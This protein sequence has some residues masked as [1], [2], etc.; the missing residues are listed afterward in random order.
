MCVNYWFTYELRLR[1][2]YILLFIF[3]FC[4]RQVLHSITRLLI[5]CYGRPD[6][7]SSHKRNQT[8]ILFYYKNTVCLYSEKTSNTKLLLFSLWITTF[9]DNLLE[10]LKLDLKDSLEVKRIKIC[11]WVKTLK[12]KNMVFFSRN[13]NSL[14]KF[15]KRNVLSDNNH[16]HIN[17]VYEL[18]TFVCT[19]FLS[20][21]VIV[22]LV[23][24][25]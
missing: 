3:R 23:D 22:V 12:E 5:I 8:N 13:R 10:S 16:P 6:I 24:L 25:V 20:F 15:L 18:L 2:P 19:Y 7:S 1:L 11:F 14:P 21:R 9:F 4:L 17:N